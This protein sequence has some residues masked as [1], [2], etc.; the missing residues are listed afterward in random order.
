MSLVSAL[1]VVEVSTDTY[2]IFRA[3]LSHI[4]PSRGSSPG[5]GLA[6]LETAQGPAY[7]SDR[8]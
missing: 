5:L 3:L 7:N 2:V 6:R 1:I 8:L 4:C